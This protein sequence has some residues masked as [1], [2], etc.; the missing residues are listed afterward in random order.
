MSSEISKDFVRNTF[1]NQS[2]GKLRWTK[3]DY[4]FRQHHELLRKCT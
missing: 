1:I 2:P 3:D 4:H